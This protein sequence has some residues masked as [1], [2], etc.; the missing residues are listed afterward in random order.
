MTD[1]EL[2][3]SRHSVR[4]YL[5]KPIEEDKISLIKEKVKAINTESGLNIQVFFN[6]IT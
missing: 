1:F 6:F 4:S 3:Q 5:D 2:M